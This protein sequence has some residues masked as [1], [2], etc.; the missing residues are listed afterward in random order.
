MPRQ[1]EKL[2]LTR[3]RGSARRHLG[4]VLALLAAVLGCG[5]GAT[6]SAEVA[7]QP[8]SASPQSLPDPVPDALR[9]QLDRVLEFTEH[10]RIM[11]LEKHAAWQLLHGVLAFGPKFEILAGDEKR[12]SPRLGLRRQTHDRL[13]L[14]AHFA[15]REGARSTPAKLGQGHDDQWLAIISQW[16]VPIN[17]PVY[18]DGKRFT[19]YDMVKYSMYDCWRGQGG[20]LDDHRAVDAPRPHRPVMDAL[21][22]AKSGPSSGSFRWKPDP[23][24][25]TRSARN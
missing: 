19:L 24:T 7:M 25:K 15:R 2:G 22:S 12:V 5:T 4:W 3:A 14:T 23:S 16:P 6:N 10:G 18:V 13:A 20:E 1:A 9:E 11:S 17:T 21:D 8:V